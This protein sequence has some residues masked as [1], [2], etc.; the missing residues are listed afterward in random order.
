MMLQMNQFMLLSYIFI[1]AFFVQ[2]TTG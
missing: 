1:F 2:W